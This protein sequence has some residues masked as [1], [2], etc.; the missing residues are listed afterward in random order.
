MYELQK[1]SILKRFSAALLDFCLV[2]ILAVGVMFLMALITGI[3]GYSDTVNKYYVEYGEKHNVDLMISQE[4]L[5]K[6]TEEYQIR[7]NEAVKDFFSNEEAKLA[8]NKVLTLPLVIITFSVLIPVLIVEFVIPLCLKH[9]RT[10]GKR[11]F[12]LGVVFKNSVKMSTTALFVRTVLGKYTIEIMAPV[13][14]LYMVFYN[15]IL[16]ITGLI[17]LGLLFVLQIVILIATKTNACIHDVLAN[18]V[19]V[20]MQTQMVF[21]SY[22]AMMQYKEELHQEEAQKA[23]Y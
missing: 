17:I 15:N 23:T 3:E 9:G 8:Y 11:V 20:D 5:N 18:T 2:V 21:E 12:N 6:E 13:M 22:D 16:G 14:L 1:A 7:Y 10:V 4:D 19:V